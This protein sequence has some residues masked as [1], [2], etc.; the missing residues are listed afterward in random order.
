MILELRIM[1][2]GP[3]YGFDCY[4][5]NNCCICGCLRYPGNSPS[6]GHKRPSKRDSYLY[7]A[8]STQMSVAN[9]L[10]EHSIICLLVEC[11]IE[12]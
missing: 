6:S 10:L 1:S 2:K 5:F 7:C 11:D 4:I 12:P 3:Y 9:I 8:C